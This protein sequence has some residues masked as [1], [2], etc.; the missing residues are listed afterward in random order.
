LGSSHGRFSYTASSPST[1][2]RRTQNTIC[3]TLFLVFV[4][5]TLPASPFLAVNAHTGRFIVEQATVS[6]GAF[7]TCSNA[8]FQICDQLGS[9]DRVDLLSQDRVTGDVLMQCSQSRDPEIRAVDWVD[10]LSNGGFRETLACVC[11]PLRHLL[12]L[13]NFLSKVT[14][15][16]LAVPPPLSKATSLTYS[17]RVLQ[18]FT[19]YLSEGAK[20]YPPWRSLCPTMFPQLPFPSHRSFSRAHPTFIY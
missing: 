12:A 11:L 19:H 6:E 8:R 4:F 10:N 5:T 1:S 7:Y 15:C 18:I 9:G 20:F 14:V 13:L 16:S 2:N 17:D 3:D